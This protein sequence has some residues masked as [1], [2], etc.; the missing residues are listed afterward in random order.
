MST[1][2]EPDLF[3]PPRAGVS[4]SRRGYF[5]ADAEDLTGAFFTQ[6]AVSPDHRREEP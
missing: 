4:P 5:Q 1:R 6:V 2:L 3:S